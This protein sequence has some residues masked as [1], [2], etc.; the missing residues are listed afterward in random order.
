M[1]HVDD[2]NQRF[3][4]LTGVI[5]SSEHS[6]NV[7]QPE[8]NHIKTEFFQADPDEPVIL[9]RN[10]IVRKLGPFKVL[11]NPETSARFNLRLLQAL[12]KWDYRVI[13]VVIDKKAHRDQYQVWHFYP[14]H[15]CLKVMVERFVRFLQDG[16]H[17]G[18]SMVESRGGDVDLQLKKSYSKLYNDGTEYISK[19]LWR[20]RL[21]S[22]E[23][24]LKPKSANIAGLQL[25][26]LIAYPS[27]REILHEKGLLPAE[28][29]TFS[30]GICNILNR[31]KYLRNHQ[32]GDIWGYGK[33]LLP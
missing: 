28:G 29:K 26:D 23:L 15:Y 6:V 22:K 2:P 14:Y 18:D 30:D 20:S 10:E 33:K 25:A 7:F 8:F 13:T 21:T 19:E 5:I 16:N 1:E 32:T 4:A 24:K 31:I 17:R 27:R 3:L 12:E 9:H 11:M